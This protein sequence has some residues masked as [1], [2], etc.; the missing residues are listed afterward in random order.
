[1]TA[2]NFLGAKPSKIF[3]KGFIFLPYL[4]LTPLLC[5]YCCSLDLFSPSNLRC[6]LADRHSPNFATCS[7]VTKIYKIRSDIWMAPSP[8]I[9][10]PESVKISARFRTTS[11]LDREYFRNATRHRQPENDFANYRHCR[12][13]KLN[14]IYF[15]LQ[16]EKNRTGVLTHPT[17]GHQA[18][19]CHASSY[20]F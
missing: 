7:M 18:G 2:E 13:E 15:G 9:W 12:T 10:R 6:H 1:M 8:E 19:Y 17:G 5:I 20:L 14:S 4:P 11:R 3:K 16:T